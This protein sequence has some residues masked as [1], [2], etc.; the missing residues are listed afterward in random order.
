MKVDLAVFQLKGIFYFS[1][2]K[3]E[4]NLVRDW[5]QNLGLGCNEM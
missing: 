4:V 3:S 5:V 2:S 1:P